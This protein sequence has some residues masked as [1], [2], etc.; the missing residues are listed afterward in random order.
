LGT[1]VA[2]GP[3]V[4]KNTVLVTRLLTM[5]YQQVDAEVENQ[6][7]AN[8]ALEMVEA[9]YCERCHRL[10]KQ[11]P[12]PHC[13]REL[14]DH[15]RMRVEGG[16]RRVTAYERDDLDESYDPFRNVA[17]P[18]RLADHV[19][20]QLLPQLKPTEVRVAEVLAESLDHRGWLAVPVDQIARLLRVPLPAVESIRKKMQAVDPIGVG[21]RDLRECFVCQLE[22]L[23]EHS[24]LG[25][26]LPLARRVVEEF[27]ESFL[28][29]RMSEIPLPDHQLEEVRAFLYQNLTPYPAMACWQSDTEGPEQPAD[30]VHY[31]RPDMVIYVDSDGKL[32]AELFGIDPSWLRLRKSFREMVYQVAEERKDEWLQMADNARLFI[33]CLAQRQHTLRRVVEHLVAYQEKAIREGDVHIRPLTRTQL[34]RE[35]NVHEATVSRAVMGKTAQLPDGRLVP[36]SRFFES[37]KSI[38]EVIRQMVDEEERALSDSEIAER[39]NALGIPIARRTVAKYRNMLKIS[40]AFLRNRQRAVVRSLDAA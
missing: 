32:A 23:Q 11:T 35:L 40:P 26:A 14:L 17:E 20:A 21:A 24:E 16:E 36:L 5:P 30:S 27:W 10:V 4:S 8:P 3:A 37:G 2:I 33:K 18:R 12:C 31:G 6:L 9:R 25:D 19:L 15:S 22:A 39:L 29:H 38:K 28:H 34:A 1:R 13:L 7:A